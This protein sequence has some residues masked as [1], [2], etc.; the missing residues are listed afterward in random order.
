MFEWARDAVSLAE[1][2]IL[3]CRSEGRVIVQPGQHQQANTDITATL[4]FLLT[5]EGQLLF[6]EG[7]P[8]F[9][10]GAHPCCFYDSGTQTVKPI[11][12]LCLGENEESV[13]FSTLDEFSMKTM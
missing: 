2:M 5:H 6:I 3:V 12:G 4:D 8:G 13:P 7:G 9:G 1:Q 11:V 10:Y